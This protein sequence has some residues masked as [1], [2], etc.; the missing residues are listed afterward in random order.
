MAL[1]AAEVDIQKCM[2][3]F[4]SILFRE[5]SPRVEES[6][7]DHLLSYDT[8]SP[9]HYLEDSIMLMDEYLILQADEEGKF[10]FQEQLSTGLAAALFAELVLRGSIALRKRRGCAVEPGSAYALEL[11]QHSHV[12]TESPI[13]NEAL[14]LLH[15]KPEEGA[16]WWL[17]VLTNYHLHKGIK[18]LASRCCEHAVQYG[19]LEKEEHT[20]LH[21]FHTKKYHTPD[22]G[23]GL[24]LKAELR[25]S[26]RNFALHGV[27]PDNPRRF[28]LIALIFSLMRSRNVIKS[29]KTSHIFTKAEKKQA[30]H[31]MDNIFLYG[32]Q[33]PQYNKYT[34]VY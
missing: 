21:L 19:L 13:L 25:D 29:V 18:H 4:V 24:A 5:V 12:P 14:G 31:N 32:N 22:R 34:N 1:A 33:E 20:V 27:R 16:V 23:H 3:T 15:K 30:L 26:I 2:A 17:R 28:A 10:P 6:E 9:H 8:V 11:T 7:I